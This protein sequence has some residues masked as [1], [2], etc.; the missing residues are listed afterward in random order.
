M[1]RTTLI[2][3]APGEGEAEF[4]ELHDYVRDFRFE[5]LGVFRYSREPDTPLGRREDQVPEEIKD[6]RLAAIM[7][8]QQEIAF[9]D[10]RDQVG[11][12]LS[13][14]VESPPAEGTARGRTWRDAPE[15]D[16]AIEIRGAP[17]PGAL[18]RVRVTDADGYDLVGAWIA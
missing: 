8:L 18:G 11:G 15:I 9:A 14:L 2:V 13:C 6:E 4:Q 1:L 17:R 10:A 16:P 7:E 3:G 12:E 5:R